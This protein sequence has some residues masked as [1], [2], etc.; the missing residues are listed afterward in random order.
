ML[1]SL[2]AHLAPAL[3]QRPSSCADATA[4][5]VAAEAIPSVITEAHSLPLSANVR[6]LTDKEIAQFREDGYVTGL[7]LFADDAVPHLQAI[8]LSPSL[9]PPPPLSRSL[10]R[11]LSLRPSLSCRPRRWKCSSSLSARRRAF[12][13]T[14]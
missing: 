7:P 6:R 4:P 2:A 5:L 3:Q 14:R 11:S 8:S 13:L 12:A 9:P 1:K 10:S